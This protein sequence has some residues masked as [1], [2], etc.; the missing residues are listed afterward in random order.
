MNLATR[1]S[2]ALATASRRRAAQISPSRHTSRTY[3]HFASQ[4]RPQSRHRGRSLLESRR[5][6]MHGSA[7]T[8][9]IPAHSIVLSSSD[10]SQHY[11]M[12]I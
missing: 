11:T 6:E 10:F 3:H 12:G 1:A 9:P 8:W 4:P 2:Q 5:R 7:G